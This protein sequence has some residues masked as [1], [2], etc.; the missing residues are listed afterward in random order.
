[1]NMVLHY[2]VDLKK[3]FHQSKIYYSGIIMWYIFPWK[4]DSH[5][6]YLEEQLVL[7]N[8]CWLSNDPAFCVGDR[9]DDSRP[10]TT[11]V[12][13]WTSGS[14]PLAR[15]VQDVFGSGLNNFKKNIKKRRRSQ[16]L[17][18]FF[19]CLVNPSFN[20]TVWMRPYRAVPLP[21]RPLCGRTLNDND[22]MSKANH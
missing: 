9:G 17:I 3:L 10:G 19:K 16:S 11:F 20:H 6:S 4:R 21:S 2:W 7:H 13:M 8:C 1:M 14:C 5:G 22:K 18:V 12:C 15:I